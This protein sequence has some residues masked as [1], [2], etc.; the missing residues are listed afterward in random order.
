MSRFQDRRGVTRCTPCWSPGHG[1]NRS[2]FLLSD[3]DRRSAGS[4]SSGLRT[5]FTSFQGTLWTDIEI[6]RFLLFDK[7][8]GR[9]EVKF[10][11][12]LPKTINPLPGGIRDISQY[13]SDAF[14]VV[15][16]RY[17]V[18]PSVAV[19]DKVPQVVPAAPCVV[20]LPACQPPANF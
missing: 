16:R 14:S 11:E 1:I 12:P 4:S 19:F 6:F 3:P 10:P 17:R 7:S 20:S 2:V 5:R 9:F 18:N 8:E 13:A 15:V